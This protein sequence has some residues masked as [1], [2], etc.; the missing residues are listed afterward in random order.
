[1]TVPMQQ[2]VLIEA[3]CDCGFNGPV[4]AFEKRAARDLYTVTWFCPRCGAG[5]T[6]LREISTQSKTINQEE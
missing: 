4:N 3:T 2:Q 6:H 5:H 1:M